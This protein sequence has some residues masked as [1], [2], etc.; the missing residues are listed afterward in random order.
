M[1]FD[2]PCHSGDLPYIFNLETLT[3]KTFSPEE[4]EFSKRIIWYWTSF[5]K[6]GNPNG[7]IQSQVNNNWL[8]KK[9]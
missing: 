6:Y 9:S 7:D 2:L 4:S 3:D 5:A 1:C 8:Y